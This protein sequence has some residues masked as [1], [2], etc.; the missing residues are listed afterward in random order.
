MTFCS[1]KKEKN[2]AR[3][4]TFKCI[5]KC[6]Q[7]AKNYRDQNVDF[8]LEESDWDD[9]NYRTYYHLHAGYGLTG[10]ESVYL[11]GIRIMSLFQEEREMHLLMQIFGEKLFVEL[12]D[13]YVSLS[14]DVG[15]YMGLNRYL[16]T[17]EER[18]AL[19]KS[20]HMI[21]GKDSEYYSSELARN[22]CFRKSLLRDTASLDNFALNKGRA[23]LRGSECYYDL[24]KESIKVK[25][26]HILQPI[27]LHFS[28]VKN[29]DDAIIPNGV[30]VFIGKNGSGKSTSIYRLAKLLYTDPTLRFKL[31]EEVGELEPNNV[32]V[33]R[34]FLISYSPFDNFILPILCD[35]DYF[36]LLES[37]SDVNSRFVFCGIRDLYSEIRSEKDIDDKLSVDN[38]I[39]D[40]Q[41]K[42]ILKSISTLASEFTQALNVVKQDF[43]LEW[44]I[45]LD[46]CR[47]A[48]PSLY[49]DIEE[50]NN[51]L[52][53]DSISIKF[54]SLSTGHK[55]F[56]HSF[57]R[58]LAYIEDNCLL[59]FD[60][61]ENHLHPPMLSF[62]ISEFR[63]VLSKNR[64]VMF[65]ATHSPV[66]VQ[67]S[68][69]KNVFVVRKQGGETSISQP[70]IETY[71]ANLSTITTEV[72]DLTTETTKYHDVIHFLYGKWRMSDRAS[73][74]LM[75]HDFEVNLGHSLTD[76]MES[77]LISLY[78]QDHV[79]A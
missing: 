39:K 9:Y 15:L 75:L 23:L 12:P 24:R 46:N 29:E 61:P 53:D 72:F 69:A 26:A 21:L 63:R 20:L 58:V 62:M 79:E 57:V 52:D 22:N 43:M 44:H 49:E 77:Y 33:S 16:A 67:E 30:L 13:N 48:Q 66:I 7:N 78:T 64:S 47:I 73:V 38:I 17:S 35:R 36:S 76:Q 3:S 59:L 55:F 40:R 74:E 10:G 51:D 18:Q 5:H 19:V 31:K 1:F 32:G 71:G 68:F 28:S 65:I 50:F 11:G 4:F 27:E 70:F 37:G 14:M 6:W 45:F 60:E 41:D 42:T 56:M 34:L 8:Y 54:M 2:M 25:F